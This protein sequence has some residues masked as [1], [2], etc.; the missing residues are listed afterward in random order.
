MRISQGPHAALNVAE[1]ASAEEV[2][3][4][5]LE[6]TKQFHPAR[7]GRMPNDIHRLANE[8]FLGI[9]AA[10]DQLIRLLGSSGRPAPGRRTSSVP[11]DG[12]QPGGTVRGTGLVS[13]IGSQPGGGTQPLARGTD[14]AGSRPGTPGNHTPATG[15]PR[16]NTPPAGIPIERQSSSM[17]EPPTNRPRAGESQPV[18]R[19]STSVIEPPTNRPRTGESQPV[20]RS[21]P[22]AGIPVQRPTSPSAPS[23]PGTPPVSNPR[24]ITPV[25]PAAVN[26][27]TVRYAGV[28]PTPPKSGAVDE[29]AELERAMNLLNANDWT[30]ARLA[31]HALA[32]KVP[33]SRRYRALL[34]YV[35]GRET[36]ATG[37]ADDALMEFQRALQLDPE[38]EIAK[39]AVRELQRK[40]RW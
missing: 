21:T 12:H 37:R 19:P 4:A 1:T 14:R 26:P 29:Q 25:A 34:C 24:S 35:R 11:V 2:R 3:A 18:Q 27:P 10:H 36:Q 30:A 15:S 7:F 38:L 8:V 20:Q 31:F 39:Q 23:R 32:A 17:I 16:R 5:F 28:Q 22:P 13:R 33:Q 6:L 40:S 9:K